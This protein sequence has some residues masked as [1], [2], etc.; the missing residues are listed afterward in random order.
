MVYTGNPRHRPSYR[1]HCHTHTPPSH[2]HTGR[3]RRKKGQ[4]LCL[5]NFCSS[6]PCCFDPH[7]PTVPK[8]YLLLEAVNLKSSTNSPRRWPAINTQ[9]P[10]LLPCPKCQDACRGLVSGQCLLFL[11]N[12]SLDNQRLQDW[13]T[14]SYRNHRVYKHTVGSVKD[15]GQKNLTT[16]SVKLSKIKL[17]NRSEQA[18]SNGCPI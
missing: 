18:S 5:R 11:R 13:F 6:T 1:H 9:P 15:R 2:S 10:A 4:L 16:S 7:L 3:K 17:T 12:T 8:V 14:S